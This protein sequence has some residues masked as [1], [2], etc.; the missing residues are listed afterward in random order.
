MAF[1]SGAQAQPDS[2]LPDLPAARITDTINLT[3]SGSTFVLLWLC[4]VPGHRIIVTSF[5]H[6]MFFVTNESKTRC[7]VGRTEKDR[8]RQRKREREKLLPYHKLCMQTNR[9]QSTKRTADLDNKLMTRCNVCNTCVCALWSMLA[10]CA[11]FRSKGFA[12][13]V[14]IAYRKFI[15]E[16]DYSAVCSRSSSTFPHISL[17]VCAFRRS[18]ESRSRQMSN[19]VRLAGSCR[20]RPLSHPHNPL[21]NISR[22]ERFK[23]PH[24]HTHTQFDAY[25]KCGPTQVHNCNKNCSRFIAELWGD[26]GNGAKK[27]Y[28]TARA[29][30]RNAMRSIGIGLRFGICPHVS[31]LVAFHVFVHSSFASLEC[32]R[33]IQAHRGP[34]ARTHTTETVGIH[35]MFMGER[36]N[37]TM[38]SY[39]APPLLYRIQYVR[40]PKTECINCCLNGNENISIVYAPNVVDLLPHNRFRVIFSS[41][42]FN[43]SVL[44]ADG[45]VRPTKKI[46]VERAYITQA[47]NSGRHA[48]KLK[49]VNMKTLFNG[50]FTTGSVPS[51]CICQNSFYVAG[52]LSLFLGIT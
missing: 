35:Q 38:D 29:W 34:I 4:T 37:T 16:F 44:R 26:T 48:I 11:F 24:A 40:F 7:V 15:V 51:Q 30:T 27:P 36:K 32:K 52:L 5:H 49:R 1:V 31:G 22:A 21:I 41:R 46:A 8:E 43:E 33:T 25:D 50:Y 39:P 12:R 14:C 47:K 3:L 10:F 17:H 42:F 13:I 19:L 18:S 9:N 20:C 28:K 23:E 45:F 2:F 6:S